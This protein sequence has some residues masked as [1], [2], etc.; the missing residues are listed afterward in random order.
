MEL[1]FTLTNIIIGITCLISLAAFNNPVLKMNL[2]HYPNREFHQGEK[3]RLL[4]S[5]F[6]HADFQHLLFN[7]MT[8]Y[9]F[10]TPL[11]EWFSEDSMFGASG[12]IIYGIFY[13]ISIVAAGMITYYKHKDNVGYTALGASGAISAVLYAFIL[14]APWSGIF[15]YFIPIPIPAVVFGAL[16]L[17]Y[18]NYASK[19]VND[20]IGHDAHFYGAV[21]GMLF[22]VA[23][24]P[25]VL[26][27]FFEQ[28]IGR[29]M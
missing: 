16:Y 3:Y 12:T 13:L 19:N 29:F 18:E 24:K 26:M 14:H 10:G 2:L 28:L 20:N 22:V 9:F 5:G 15:I 1:D 25:V 17:W 11:N 23:L 8:L 6:I 27:E 21:F 7:M 4:S